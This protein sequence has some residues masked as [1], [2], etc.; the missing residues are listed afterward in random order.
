WQIRKRP[1]LPLRSGYFD[2]K[3]IDIIST[4]YYE[5][6]I[7]I[8]YSSKSRKRFKTVN[9]IGIAF[10]ANDNP[11]Q[12]LWRSDEPFWKI[13]NRH[14][15]DKIIGASVDGDKIVLYIYELHKG[16]YSVNITNPFM[17]HKLIQQKI[18]LDRYSNNPI[19][20]PENRQS[21]EAIGTFNPAVM[22]GKD[23][24]IH[25]LYR[26]IGADGISRLG[27]VSSS[28]GFSFDD[29]L[30]YPVYTMKKSSR[31][32][33]EQEYNP[34]TN[35]SGGSWSGTEDPRM[36]SI[37]GRVYVTFNTFD[38]WNFIRASVITVNEDDLLKK[39]FA[40]G[41]PMYLSP[42]G[43]IH[44]NWVI[45]P[46]KING[47]FAILHS[48]S[49]ELQ[50]DYVDNLE[51]LH[52]NKK[53]IKSRFGQKQ[54]R[55]TWDTWLRGVGPPPIKTDRGWLILYHAVDKKYPNQ[56][57]L[58]AKLLDLKN[59]RKIIAR[60]AAPV[61]VPSQWYENESK[62]GVIYACGAIIKNGQLLVYY[63]G[64][65]KHV[66]IASASIDEFIKELLTD[67]KPHLN[68]NQVTIS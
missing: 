14:R 65:D 30:P 25:M 16:I 67:R 12:L 22:V 41:E 34:I 33:K 10:L 31:D 43:E 55:K 36:V 53:R 47:K 50:I 40:W 48:I 28:D 5:Q 13:T 38:G 18:S 49:P 3:D 44:K 64:G 29:S 60:S 11:A 51:D 63:G 7:M 68:F 24:R 61:L 56:Y 52:N 20:A 9:Q 39:N 58:G 23:G 21:W 6:G 57:R 42:L 8:I 27:Y 17:T 32:L 26:A 4:H 62:P 15:G 1:V 2:E 66:C 19:I 45:F 54:P 46:E 37:E 59:P 35:P